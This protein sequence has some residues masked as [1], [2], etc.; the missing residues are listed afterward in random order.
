MKISVQ[1][2]GIEE[3]LGF[4]KTYSLI[5]GAG[6]EAVDWNI[7][8]GLKAQNIRGLCYEGTS[9]FERSI[10][11]V[12]AYYEEE[13]NT[14]KKYGLSITQAHAP[15]P[16]YVPGHPEVLEYCIKIYSRCI[17][18]CDYAGCK[19]LIIHGISL[20]HNDREN[21]PKEIEKLNMHLYESLIP[22]LLKSNV[23]V[24]LE[25]LFTSNNGI[26]TEGVCSDAH[27]AVY[28]I[29]KLNEKAGKEVFGF[30]LDV[31]HLQLLGKNLR[32]YIPILDKRIKA[33]HVHDNDGQKDLHLA[34]FTGKISW[35]DFCSSLKDIG[36]EGD[37][38][39]ETFAQAQKIIEFDESLLSAWLELIA[40]TG[41]NFRK[42]ILK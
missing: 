41:D 39:F 37:I 15:F 30:C 36:Y 3:Y 13:L 12:R 35:S 21:T 29:D 28:Y 16:A 24:C 9:I 17:E 14:I 34:P 20:S 25:N 1:T 22:A 6:F 32:N 5:S 10:D 38:S 2:G 8:H 11:E 31:G 7:D 18:L 33:L 40:K 42:H 19:K 26:I 23:M 27:E 4:E